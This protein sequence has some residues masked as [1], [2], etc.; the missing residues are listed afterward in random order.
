MINVALLCANASPAVRPFMSS[1]VGMLNGRTAPVGPDPGASS[2]QMNLMTDF[3][4]S[5]ETNTSDGQIESIY[6]EFAQADSDLY[7]L[8]GDSDIL[9]DKD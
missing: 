3:L 7:L 2:E 5:L 1:V 8:N 9:E 6:S 4:K